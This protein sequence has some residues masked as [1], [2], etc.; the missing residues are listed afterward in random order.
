[1]Q[2]FLQTLMTELKK[3]GVQFVSKKIDAKTLAQLPEKIIFN[4]AGLGN[5]ELFNDSEMKGIKGHILEFK[6]ENPS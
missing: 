1:M 3:K 2:P 6:N 5:R 4:C